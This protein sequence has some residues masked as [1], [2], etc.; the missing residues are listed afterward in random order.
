MGK[1]HIQKI[2]DTTIYAEKN[3][4]TNFARTEKKFVLSL[5]YYNGDIYLFVN[6]RQELQ[7][8]TKNDQM[9]IEE[10]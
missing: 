1:D 6:S 9:S 10:K 2:N 8:K 5:H 4:H 7:F 3:F